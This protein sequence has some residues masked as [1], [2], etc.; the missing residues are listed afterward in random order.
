MFF[1]TT[2]NWEKS[3]DSAELCQAGHFPKKG[4]KETAHDHKH[5]FT[6]P[7]KVMFL[8]LSAE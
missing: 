7:K 6:L 1:L 5:I 8:S 4:A 3:T 2:D